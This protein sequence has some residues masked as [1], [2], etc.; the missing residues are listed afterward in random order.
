MSRGHRRNGAE[1]DGRCDE[2]K[3]EARH[4]APWLWVLC[5]N[6]SPAAIVVATNPNG[7][8]D[9]C[10]ACSAS[11]PLILRTLHGDLTTGGT[12]LEC[13][14]MNTDSRVQRHSA[15]QWMLAAEGSLDWIEETG[16]ANGIDRRN[17]LPLL[18]DTTC[19]W[20]A[21]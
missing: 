3:E 18:V 20:P 4:A 8:A 2:V 14:N 15:R 10:D 13:A 7:P 5:Q 9:Q 6:P 21:S 19:K 12:H 17:E 16:L 11:C 1:T